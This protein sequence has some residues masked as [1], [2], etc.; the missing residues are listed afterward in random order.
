MLKEI[1]ELWEF[2]YSENLEN[3][4]EGFHQELFKLCTQYENEIVSLDNQIITLENKLIEIGYNHEVEILTYK[5]KLR[6]LEIEIEK[7]KK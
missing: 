4:Y 3:E 2:C 5:L 7:I 1:E 6:N